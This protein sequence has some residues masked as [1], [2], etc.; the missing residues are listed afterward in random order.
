MT[1]FELTSALYDIFRELSKTAIF[2]E[3]CDEQSSTGPG[4]CIYCRTL[5]ARFSTEE[6]VFPEGL[7]NDE[8]ILEKGYVCDR[9]NNGLLA[10]LDQALLD[11]GPIAFLRVLYVPHTK[12]GKFPSANLRNMAI[13]KTAPTCIAIDA[14]D[15]TGLPYNLEDLGNDGV[16]FQFSASKHMPNPILIGRA[17]FK[18]ALGMI[19]YNHSAEFAL[20]ERYEPARA[21]VRGERGFP[22]R[23]ILATLA[24]PHRNLIVYW[25]KLERGTIFFIDIFGVVAVFN[26][27]DESPVPFPDNFDLSKCIVFEL[28]KSA[29]AR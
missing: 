8:I 9:C 13:K 22:N 28:S 10:Q 27:E 18:I 1:G 11:F 16:R 5:E 23:L 21:F 7:G 24:E 12:G 2:Q 15:R 3:L 6:H 17:Y 20:A 4:Q 25:Q 14:K 29:A 19:A 26:M